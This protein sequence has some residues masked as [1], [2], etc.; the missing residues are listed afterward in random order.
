MVA[1]VF[2]ERK[3]DASA[4]LEPGILQEIKHLSEWKIRE[5]RR[6]E[7][8][9]GLTELVKEPDFRMAGPTYLWA[10][11]GSLE[12]VRETTTVSDGDLVRN[13]RMAIQLMRQIRGQLKGEPELQDR[14]AAAIEM[15]NR[16]EVDAKR[17]LELG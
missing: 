15:M 5:F 9:A 8:D 7:F 3:G 2:E 13:F 14:F 12:E 1:V 17:Q 4:H 11:G 10:Q 6:I 16:D